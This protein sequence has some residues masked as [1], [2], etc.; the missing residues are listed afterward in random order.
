MQL[1][2]SLKKVTGYLQ[3]KIIETN[4]SAFLGKW[5][6][7]ETQEI[8]FISSNFTILK[9]TSFFPVSCITILKR[10]ACQQLKALFRRTIG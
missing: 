7:E 3:L 1:P 10:K 4:I 8:W 5:V 6:I 2:P 9:K